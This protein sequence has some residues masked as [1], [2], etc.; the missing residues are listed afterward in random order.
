MAKTRERWSGRFGFVLATIGS[1]VGLGSIW[2]FPY[3]V[4]TNG[5][6]AFVVFY[7]A[8]LAFIVFPLLLAEFSIGRRGRSD[9]AGSIDSVAEANRVSSRWS[10][11]GSLGVLSSYLILSFYSVIGG[12]TIAYA[13]SGMLHG[14]PGAEAAEVQARFDTLLASPLEM[15][16]YHAAFML[17]TAVIVARGIMHGIEAAVRILMPVLIV[18]IVGLAVYS[19]LEGDAAAATRFMFSLDLDRFT[20]QAALEAVGLGFFSISVGLGLMIV[21]AAYAG[22]EINLRQVALITIVS[23]TTISFLSGFA[24]FPIVFAHG[25]DPSSGPG[26]LFVTLPLAFAKMPF[27][28]I[29]ALTFFVL[30]FVAALASAI[31]LLEMPVAWLIRRFGWPRVRAVVVAA[32]SCWLIGLATV[33]SFNYWADWFPLGAI[34]GLER[35]TIFDLTDHLTSNLMLPAGGFAISIF[36]GWKLSD[37]LLASELELGPRMT[38]LLHGLLR[39]VA[40]LGIGAAAIAPAL[41]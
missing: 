18:L 32:G 10:L 15:G 30:L 31:S 3:E 41:F 9:T 17:I 7:L 24:I 27:G 1:A 39:Y 11:V 19:I 36:V 5:G 4:G 23:D 21:Y 2:K 33:F 20:G 13:L 12:W 6:S 29:T 35:A 37:R 8:G 38:A 14:L 40:P 16:I 34:R 25:L 26:L 22:P 28:A